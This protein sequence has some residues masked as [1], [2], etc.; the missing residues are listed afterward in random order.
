ML[1]FGFRTWCLVAVLFAGFGYLGAGGITRLLP[2]EDVDVRTEI[3]QR[4]AQKVS[5]SLPELPDR[6]RV[7]VARVVSDTEGILTRE[8]RDWIGRQNVRMVY[9]DWWLEPGYVLGVTSEPQSMHHASDRIRKD[10]VDYIVCAKID[11]WVTYP[12][13]QA[14]LVG[15]IDIL[16]ASTGASV[17]SGKLALPDAGRSAGS[18]DRSGDSS[19]STV[20]I[21]SRHRTPAAQ[22]AKQLDASAQSVNN[23]S[24]LEESLPPASADPVQHL[25]AISMPS[26]LPLTVWQGL[27]AW[28]MSVILLPFGMSEPIR[29][30]LK[31][32]SN[33][34][35][36]LL[37][38]SW[39]VLVILSAW[40]FWGWSLSI[41]PLMLALTL[42]SGVSVAWFG[43]VCSRLT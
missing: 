37:L 17:Y 11:E 39:I 3:A 23:A 40:M 43:L 13:Y 42:S 5:V 28:L 8:L 41:F 18:S 27:T 30:V 26:P 33:R 14:R 6:P 24:L 34:D 38:L 15:T 1:A 16:D 7:A 36:G 19:I 12:A 4:W 32:R 9:D 35:N 20:K 10:N 29:R 21:D 22:T 2:S 25:A 31:R